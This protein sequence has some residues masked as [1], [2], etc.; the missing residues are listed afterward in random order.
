MSP[1][2][3]EPAYNEE[4]S[5]LNGNHEEGG[6]HNGEQSSIDKTNR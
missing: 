5:A 4:Q 3:D 2:G 6:T 1:K